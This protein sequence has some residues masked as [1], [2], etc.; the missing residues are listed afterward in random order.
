MLRPRESVVAQ[1]Y[2]AAV[3]KLEEFDALRAR[4]LH[5]ARLRDAHFQHGLVPKEVERFTHRPALDDVKPSVRAA[6]M[7]D[8]HR[9]LGSAS[10][11]ETQ[12]A[13]LAD[14]AENV[15]STLT[16]AQEELYYATMAH[17]PRRRAATGASATALSPSLHTSAAVLLRASSA[18][19]AAGAAVAALAGAAAAAGHIAPGQAERLQQQ[20]ASP[21]RSSMAARASPIG[22][23]LSPSQVD[24]YVDEHGHDDHDDDGESLGARPEVAGALH[25]L[26]PSVGHSRARAVSESAA[27]RMDAAEHGRLL[28][29]QAVADV[30]FLLRQPSLPAMRHG[31][32]VAVGGLGGAHHPYPARHPLQRLPG[33]SAA[34]PAPALPQLRAAMF[35]EEPQ[36]QAQAQAG[37]HL[38]HEVRSGR[39]EPPLPLPP[40]HRRARAAT[41][42]ALL[43]GQGLGLG[44]P[45]AGAGHAHP[46]GF[47]FGSQLHL[48][49]SAARHDDDG[50]DDSDDDDD[51]DDEDSAESDVDAGAGG[52]ARHRHLRSATGPL[53]PSQLRLFTQTL[54]AAGSTEALVFAEQARRAARREMRRAVRRAARAQAQ[55]AGQGAGQGQGL[56]AAGSPRAPGAGAAA[57]A[58]SSGAASGDGDTTRGAG[59]ELPVSG[60]ALDRY[61]LASMSFVGAPGTGQPAAHAAAGGAAA[62]ASPAAGAEPASEQGGLRLPLAAPV[63]VRGPTGAVGGIA[64]VIPPGS[65]LHLLRTLQMPTP[66][67]QPASSGSVPAPAPAVSSPVKAALPP[68]PAPAT[69]PSA[70]ATFTFVPVSSTPGAGAAGAAS[71]SPSPSPAPVAAQP[72][73]PGG[74]GG[75]LGHGGG[76]TPSGPPVSG[77][78]LGLSAPA[79]GGAVPAAPSATTAAVNDAAQP[80]TGAGA[81]AARPVS[82]GGPAIKTPSHLLA[83]LASGSGSRTGSPSAGG[84]LNALAGSAAGSQRNAMAALMES[85]LRELT[86]GL[87]PAIPAGDDDDD[88]L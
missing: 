68:A 10:L 19:D 43:H 54:A 61:A 87:S 8:V 66:A 76:S 73:A 60:L 14:T 41:E 72:S 52:A 63:P 62:S 75:G 85:R 45:M 64:A 71:G 3:G 39:E 79:A 24:A 86:G 37:P 11:Q 17:S 46:A 34:G 15:S 83:A 58:S 12:H 25:G 27:A 38:H 22:F 30:A 84:A 6:S 23:D 67:Q 36:L 56:T 47:G 9:A 5:D 70:G 88:D 28:G 57:A 55:G 82:T 53:T 16:P 2:V 69:S 77:L 29:P 4:M 20:F 48:A 50:S 78:R 40:A 33:R 32:A 59:R 7:L 44:R 49:R 65:P 51:D 21:H 42:G 74:L 31:H 26:S 18:V 81:V 80:S 1:P 13:V 35:S